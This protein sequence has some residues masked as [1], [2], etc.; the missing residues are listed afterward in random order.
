M[1]RYARYACFVL[2]FNLLVILLGTVVRATNSGDGCG[3]HWPICNGELIPV[4]PA[5]KTVIEYSHRLTSG[6]D[7]L[8]ILGLCAGAVRAFPR[9]HRVRHAAFATLV[10]TL[11]EG[12]LGRYLVK[13]RLV[14]DDASAARALWM[15][16]HLCNTLLLLAACTLTAA[17]ASG[18]PAPRPTL[19]RGLLLGGALLLVVALGVSGAVTALGDTVF[20]VR[21]HEDVLRLA[22]EPGAH[23]LLRQRIYHPYV[24]L[25]VGVLLFALTGLLPT[26]RGPARLFGALVRAAFVLQIGIGLVNLWL[27][28]PV[29]M[30]V[31]HLLGADLLWVALVLYANEAAAPLV[32]ARD[33][34]QPDRSRP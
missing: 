17:F 6:L 20:P 15:S 3:S 21:S 33:D 31:L 5:L 10:L 23:F 1:N 27:R 11:I 9:G 4:A 8:L 18:R 34:E 2:V 16:I 28:A 13:A 32:S 24:S 26:P 12:W 19:G 7:G 22:R 29:A 25:G 30:Q 14:A